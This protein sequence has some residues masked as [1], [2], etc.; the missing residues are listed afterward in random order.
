MLILKIVKV[1]CF[2]TPLQ[3][4]ILNAVSERALE[5]GKGRSA[6]AG[7]RILVPG[8]EFCA[9]GEAKDGWR[10]IFTT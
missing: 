5:T 2:A 6:A 4:L 10:T 8:Q 1:L 9:L 7:P 3:V